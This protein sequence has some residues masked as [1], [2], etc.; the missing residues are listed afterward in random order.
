MLCPP[1]NKV[2]GLLTNHRGSTERYRTTDSTQTSNIYLNSR[3]HNQHFAARSG[4]APNGPAPKNSFELVETFFYYKKAE[5][6][7]NSNSCHCGVTSCPFLGAV[8]GNEETRKLGGKDTHLP[9]LDKELSHQTTNTSGRW[10][11][12]HRVIEWKEIQHREHVSVNCL[13]A[14]SAF[15][16]YKRTEHS[17]LQHI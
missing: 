2:L 1:L 7:G 16:P 5:V 3:A 10:S 13:G 15:L 11:P 14:Y 8:Q 17:L 6:A 12:A 4:P 9:L